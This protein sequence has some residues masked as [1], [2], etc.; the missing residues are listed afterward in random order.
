[1]TRGIFPTVVILLAFL[2][3]IFFVILPEFQDFVDHL[4]TLVADRVDTWLEA[5]LP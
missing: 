5:Q 4:A 1:M 3:V 2:A